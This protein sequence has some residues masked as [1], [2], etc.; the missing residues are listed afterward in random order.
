[1]NGFHSFC[2]DIFGSLVFLLFLFFVFVEL[3]EFF[4]YYLIIITLRRSCLKDHAV[5]FLMWVLP[6]VFLYIFCP[7]LSL[8]GRLETV[9]VQL[10]RASSLRLF[11]LLVHRAVYPQIR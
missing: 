1:M 4:L 2:W 10:G 6:S 5:S 7:L 9:P 8:F 3:N 11:P